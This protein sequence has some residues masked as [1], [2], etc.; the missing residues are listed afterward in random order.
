MYSYIPTTDP[1]IKKTETNPRFHYIFYEQPRNS[2]SVET[3]NQKF[4]N[5]NKK[6]G[7]KLPLMC[8]SDEGLVWSEFAEKR[9][10]VAMLDAFLETQA[11]T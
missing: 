6:K 1:K 9:L 5:T 8:V 11:S 7:K 3:Q 2:K 10:W 4:S